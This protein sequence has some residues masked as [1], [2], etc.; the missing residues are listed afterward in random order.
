MT[1][2]DGEWGK[3]DLMEQVWQNIWWRQWN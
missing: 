1:H 2:V 3:L